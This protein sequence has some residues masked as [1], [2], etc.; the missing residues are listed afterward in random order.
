ME[1]LRVITKVDE[2]TAWC[3]GMVAVPKKSGQVRMYIERDVHLLPTV[4]K[5]LAQ[6]H[7]ATVFSKLDA[8][9]GFWQI[10]VA[11]DSSHPTI[12]HLL[13]DI[14]SISCPLVLVLQLNTF[15]NV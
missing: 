8:N 3:S 12:V 2:P 1:S 15:K 7:C 6:L 13:V 5:T 9:Y 11:N 14:V 10:P 4:D